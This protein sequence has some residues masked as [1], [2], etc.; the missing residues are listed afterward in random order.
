MEKK[1]FITSDVNASPT[2]SMCQDGM[3]NN[4]EVI[5]DVLVKE[6]DVIIERI[7]RS[8]FIKFVINHD[9]I[10]REAKD[11]AFIYLS[12]FS[13]VLAIDK[14]ASDTST[15]SEIEFRLN[16]NS[17]MSIYLNKVVV[18]TPLEVE[19]GIV[20][21]SLVCNGAISATS[22]NVPTINATT[23]NVP[24]INATII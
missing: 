9:N 10:N 23:I 11:Y 8:T 7:E 5:G 4:L 2:M 16:G 15:K 6:G 19:G 18:L 24:T 12:N 14:Y 17:K 13:F 3:E 22:L 1:M 21:Q 20:C